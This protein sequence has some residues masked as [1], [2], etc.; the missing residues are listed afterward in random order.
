MNRRSMWTIGIALVWLVGLGGYAMSAEDKYDVKVPGGL[1]MSEFK[2]YEGWQASV[3]WP[4]PVGPGLRR[5][6]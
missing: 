5:P 1:A 2:G 3:S 6:R 4:G